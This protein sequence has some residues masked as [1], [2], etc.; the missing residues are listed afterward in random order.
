MNT[1]L[2]WSPLLAATVARKKATAP[3]PEAK[4]QP[5]I[6]QSSNARQEKRGPG[7]SRTL[8]DKLAP[9]VYVWLGTGEAISGWVDSEPLDVG[10][11]A[12]LLRRSISSPDKKCFGTAK[13]SAS[14]LLYVTGCNSTTSSFG[15]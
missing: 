9:G 3:F 8:D 13:A 5:R 12:F 10:N 2:G 14:V 15:A 7:T 6:D 4:K 1:R 11:V